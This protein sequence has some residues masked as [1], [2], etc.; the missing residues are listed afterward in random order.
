MR[1][2]DLE[3]NDRG[4]LYLQSSDRDTDIENVDTKGGSR[5]EE[6]RDWKDTIHC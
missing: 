4:D 5:W 6:L 2:Y 3:K 1:I